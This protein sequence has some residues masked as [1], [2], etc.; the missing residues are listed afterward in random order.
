MTDYTHAKQHSV[1]DP[2]CHS[3]PGAT[4]G[5]VLSVDADGLLVWVD[6][7]GGA[8][9][10]LTFAANWSNYGADFASGQFKKVGDLVFLRGLVLC[11]AVISPSNLVI[12]TLPV[13]YRPSGHI[14][15]PGVGVNSWSS[16]VSYYITSDGVI[17]VY[18]SN[19]AV[20]GWVS[21]NN[22]VFSVV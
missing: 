8:W 5:K 10:D 12:A 7:V 11:S 2:A 4:T 22:I 18:G 19:L 21:L 13:G 1:L 20:S 17:S 3:A 15:V 9:Q 14:G 16:F 6:P